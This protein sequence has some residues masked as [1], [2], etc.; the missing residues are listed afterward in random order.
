MRSKWPVASDETSC[1]RKCR[2]TKKSSLPAVPAL[3][4]LCLHFPPLSRAP[5]L[6]D[7][8]PHHKNP[9]GSRWENF[10]CRKAPLLSG[11]FSFGLCQERDLVL[12]LFSLFFFAAL[13]CRRRREGKGKV[14]NK[15]YRDIDPVEAKDKKNLI[16]LIS[17]TNSWTVI[18]KKKRN[19]QLSWDF[20]DTGA[21]PRVLVLGV[22]VEACRPVTVCAGSKN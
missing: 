16:N 18:K 1:T 8:L 15:I 17:H 19:K 11:M 12:F 4:L 13:Q 3:S 10:P 21:N 6:L 20:M 7:P 9:S 22:L 5:L 14:I 2:F